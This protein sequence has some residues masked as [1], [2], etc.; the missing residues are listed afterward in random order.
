MK[1]RDSLSGDIVTLELSG[2][3]IAGDQLTSFLG[4]VQYYLSL[5]KSRFLIDL[6]DVERMNS[7]G[8]G[9]LV[10][11]HMAATHAGG[12]FVLANITNVENL[13]NVTQLLRVFE[14]YDSRDEAVMALQQ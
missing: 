1:L 5:N 10:A 2:K 3:L 9:A 7:A 11:A 6:H 4:R 13:L 12:K 14:S 8:I